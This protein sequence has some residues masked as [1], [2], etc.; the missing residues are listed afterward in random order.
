MST[1]PAS[2][3]AELVHLAEHLFLRPQASSD[4]N[5]IS[6][7]FLNSHHPMKGRRARPVR[8]AILSQHLPLRHP[9]LGTPEDSV[10]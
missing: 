2:V 3:A 8:P 7:A 1:R 5:P 4:F 9:I 6:D 10:T